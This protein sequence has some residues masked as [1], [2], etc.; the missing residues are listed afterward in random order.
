[1]IRLRTQYRNINFTALEDG[2]LLMNGA[3]VGRL[4]P[5]E[6]HFLAISVLEAGGPELPEPAKATK[7]VATIRTAVAA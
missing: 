7:K 6:Y 3:E 5:G 1:M 4:F 2:R